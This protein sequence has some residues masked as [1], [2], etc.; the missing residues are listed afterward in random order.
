MLMDDE[1]PVPVDTIEVGVIR[2]SPFLFGIV[3]PPNPYTET[4]PEIVPVDAITVIPE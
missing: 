3:Q 2:C 1:F 4:R